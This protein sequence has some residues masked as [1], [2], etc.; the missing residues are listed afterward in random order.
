ISMTAAAVHIAVWTVYQARLRGGPLTALDRVLLAALAVLG[1]AGL[2]P[3]LAYS[4]H[5]EVRY[6]PWLGV[7][8]YDP[9]PTVWGDFAYA[10]FALSL[11]ITFVRVVL[12]L[13]RGVPRARL[14]AWVLGVITVAGLNDM[15]ATA[16]AVSSPNLL[17]IGFALTLGMLG[18]SITRRF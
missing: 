4:L 16:G 13:R 12:D 18:V 1:V 14:S 2:V 6:V 17:G 10:L 15:L 5:E 8:Y 7:R 11:L 3:G 9:A